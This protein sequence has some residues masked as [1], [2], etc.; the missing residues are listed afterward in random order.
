MTLKGGLRIL[1]GDTA[2]GMI[3]YCC[4]IIEYH[5]FPGRRLTWGGPFNGQEYRQKLFVS[6]IEAF[7]PAAII[8]TGTYRG[9]TTEFM[10]DFGIPIYSVEGDPQC[11]AFARARLW[12]KRHVLIHRGDSRE[13]LRLFFNGP[14][15]KGGSQTV[16][17]YLD[18]HGEGDLPLADELRVVFDSCRS[19]V[20]MVDD[21]QVPDDL[22][23]SYDDYGPGNALT[24][25]YIAGIVA[26]CSLAMFVP[27]VRGVSETG[28]RRGC[29]VLARSDVHGDKLASLGLL[30]RWQEKSTVGPE[31]T[32]LVK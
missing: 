18:A 5:L 26:A 31:P 27:S 13:A 20:V 32:L 11:C 4:G 30:R 7:K 10:A 29:V 21:F 8:E 3:Y 22:D 19:A 28:Y 6:L 16:L 2:C 1:L 15:Q 14:L 24:P 9:T 25:E 12:R 17:V 23:Y